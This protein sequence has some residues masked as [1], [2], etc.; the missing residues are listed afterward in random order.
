[1]KEGE[2]KPQPESRK[3]KEHGEPF[4]TCL[5][6]R[7]QKLGLHKVETI[8]GVTEW[9]CGRHKRR[10]DLTGLAASHIKQPTDKDR[11]MAEYI[12]DIIV[13]LPAIVTNPATDED[14]K[15]LQAE[16]VDTWNTYDL[17]PGEMTRQQSI[18]VGSFNAALVDVMDAYE[19][20]KRGFED[21]IERMMIDRTELSEIEGWHETQEREWQISA[22]NNG[23]IVGQRALLSGPKEGGDAL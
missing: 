5:Y 20:G 17:E 2:P 19:E 14:T 8:D 12:R 3:Q 9:L 7:D 10:A 18:L 16:R 6:C 21:R 13:K 22:Y 1:M 23:L 15:T 4:C 11:K